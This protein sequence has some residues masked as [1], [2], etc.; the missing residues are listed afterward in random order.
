MVLNVQICATLKHVTTN[1]SREPIHEEDDQDEDE[2]NLDE[3]EDDE[4]FAIDF[5]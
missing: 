2:L 5:D 3:N 4:N 1:H